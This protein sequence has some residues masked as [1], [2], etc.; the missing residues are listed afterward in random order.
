VHKVRACLLGLRESFGEIVFDPVLPATLDGL[1]ARATLCGRPVELR[2]RVKK[3]CF[4]PNAVSVN[5]TSLTGGRREANPYRAGGLCFRE[6]VLKALLSPKDN[7]IL[8]D[9]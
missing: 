6:D 1:V 4:A 5:G 8:V 3:G 7:V 2:Y 9:L